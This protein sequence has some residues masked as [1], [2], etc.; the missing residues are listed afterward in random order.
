[1]SA[2]EQEFIHSSERD[3]L[4]LAREVLAAEALA[5]RLVR[6]RLGESFCRAAG[7]LFDRCSSGGTVF[8]TGMGK[9]GLVGQKIAATLASTGTR[10]HTLHPADALHGDLGRIAPADVVLMLSYSGETEEVMRLIRPIRRIG[11][12]IVAITAR[13]SSQL[14]GLSDEAILLGPIEEACPLRLAP[15]AS[16]TA[17]MGVGDALAFV[18]SQRRKFKPE[19]FAQFHPGGSL[20]KLS[21]TVDEVMR[22]GQQ[23]RLAKYW[24]T[25][26]EALIQTHRHGRRT[27]ALL[28]VDEL[29]VLKG[30]FTDGDLARLLEK[31]RDAD[32]DCPVAELMNSQPA[33]V[34]TGTRVREAIEILSTRKFSQVPV[35]DDAGRLVGI[36]DITDLIGLVPESTSGD[37]PAVR[38]SQRTAA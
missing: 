10:S 6:D 29:G 35:L 26:R 3:Q 1:M 31:R 8:V 18:I 4:A 24:L 21:S 14:A 30:I 22:T 20:G 19:N 37:A 33:V 34:R 28:L 15:S 36:V 16:T 17:M 11:A 25:V 5:I 27:G 9:A 38:A 32:L 12:S 13:G 2:T 23:L 7:V